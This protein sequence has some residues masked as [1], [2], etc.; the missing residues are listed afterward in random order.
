VAD[1]TRLLQTPAVSPAGQIDF[2]AAVRSRSWEWLLALRHRLDVDLQLVDESCQ[3]ILKQDPLPS[4]I[5]IAGLLSSERPAL[6]AAMDLAHQ[7][8]TTQV[9]TAEAAQIACVPVTAVNIGPGGLIVAGRRSADPTVKS[10]PRADLQNIGEW[11]RI[12][13]QAH[14]ATAVADDFSRV[15]TLSE[16]LSG[17]GSGDSDGEMVLAWAEA[18]AIW[19]D[20]DVH[21]YVDD[22]RGHFV[23]ET[24]FPGKTTGSAPPIL[25]AG[26]FAQTSGLTLLARAEAERLHFSTQRDVMIWRTR[27]AP[28]WLLVF[29]GSAAPHDRRRLRAYLMLLEQWMS[30]GLQESIHHSIASMTGHLFDVDEHAQRNAEGAV[31]ALRESLGFAAAWLA[32]RSSSGAPV[33]IVGDWNTE[34]A[35]YDPASRHVVV[36]RAE[37]EHSLVLGV[38]REKERHIT[39]QDVKV[40]DAAADLLD[41]W[42]R[43]VL[44]RSASAIERRAPTRRFDDLIE[45]LAGQAVQ[46]GVPITVLVVSPR[47]SKTPLSQESV[48]NLKHHMR[49][50]DMIGLLS[51]GDIGLLLYDTPG[52]HAPIIASRVR[53]LIYTSDQMVGSKGISVGFASRTPGQLQLGSIL[54]DARASAGVDAEGIG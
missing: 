24:S 27:A 46:T 7:T 17:A 49:P 53:Q 44:R 38:A 29:R 19:Q 51:D 40:V 5:N 43:R 13:V 11:L 14:L 50:S 10:R 26:S 22:L 34:A 8:H 6:L 15:S 20:L 54:Q 12:A 23:H 18:V 16:V 2:G 25:D 31:G 33:V 35:H 47:G 28:G 37:Q 32:L 36:R 30:R 21:A 42:A 45:S 3:P 39:P 1:P 52:P 9:V 41:L 48:S 4:P